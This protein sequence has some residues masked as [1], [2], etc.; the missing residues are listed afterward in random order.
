M[1][2][3]KNLPEIPSREHACL[4]ASVKLLKQCFNEIGYESHMSLALQEGL[5]Q[6]TWTL[7]G[8]LKRKRGLLFGEL[9]Q[10]K[11]NWDRVAARFK[12]KPEDRLREFT[13]KGETFVAISLVPNA[14]VRPLVGLIRSTGKRVRFEAD[15]LDTCEASTASSRVKV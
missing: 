14:D 2:G 9:G 13:C 7:Q 8:R 1:A 6:P 4:L 12:F 15:V 10:D 5:E 11:T 3:P